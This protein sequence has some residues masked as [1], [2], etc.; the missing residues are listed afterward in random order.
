MKKIEVQGAHESLFIVIEPGAIAASLFLMLPYHSNQI[1][2]SAK[3]LIPVTGLI[4][5]AEHL[6]VRLL[7]FQCRHHEIRETPVT[8]TSHETLVQL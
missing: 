7:I 2:A 4:A 8:Y 1:Q 3:T 6:N 5:T